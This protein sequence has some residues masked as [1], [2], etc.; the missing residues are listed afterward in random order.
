MT[1]TSPLGPTGTS[2][3]GTLALTVMVAVV[4]AAVGIALLVWSLQD[5][6]SPAPTGGSAGA[7]RSPEGSRTAGTASPEASGGTVAE[8]R[9]VPPFTGV[10]LAGAGPVVV[11]VGEPQSVV[12]HA[13]Q[14]VA[15]RITTTVRDGVLVIGADRDF[16]TDRPLRVEVAVPT[17]TSVQLSGGGTVDVDGV[18]GQRFTADL[19]GSGRLTARGETAELVATLSGSGDMELH[20]LAAEDVTAAVSGSGLIRV[21]A[22]SSLDAEVSGAGAIRYTGDPERVSEEVTGV[23]SITA[24]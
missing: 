23:G 9:D 14:D 11:R 17:L 1:T 3:R 5:D 18:S 4:A 16:S 21:H 13:E 10:D 8:S 15:D 6:D 24:E 19:P 20:D 12:V 7:T 2:R 22:T